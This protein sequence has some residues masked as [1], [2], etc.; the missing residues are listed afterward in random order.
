P[1]GRSVSQTGRRPGTNPPA[2]TRRHRGSFRRAGLHRR[3]WIRL[4]L[5]ARTEPG[6]AM[7]QKLLRMFVASSIAAAGLLA[8]SGCSRKSEPGVA[9]DAKTAPAPQWKPYES[10]LIQPILFTPADLDP[11]KNACTNLAD[12]VNDK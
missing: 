1:G 3:R 5:A 6:G 8:Q 4:A 2:S 7:T 9:A 10:A 12:Y 11:A